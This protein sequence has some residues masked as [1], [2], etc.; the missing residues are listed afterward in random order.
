MFGARAINA[1]QLVECQ[2]AVL[3]QLALFWL[4]IRAEVVRDLCHVSVPLLAAQIICP[5]E[6]LAFEQGR[7]SSV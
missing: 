7:E 1:R 6:T 3:W 2:R 5:K 4:A